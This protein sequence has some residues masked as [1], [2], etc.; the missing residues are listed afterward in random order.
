MLA[1]GST[2]LSPRHRVRSEASNQ[3]KACHYQLPSMSTQRLD[4]SCNFPRRDAPRSQLIRPVGLSVE[5]P[6]EGRGSCSMRPKIRLSPSLASAQTALWEGRREIEEGLWERERNNLKRI[7]EQDSSDEA[8]TN[9]ATKR[10]RSGSGTTTPADS[11]DGERMRMSVN[12]LESGS[13]WFPQTAEVPGPM[14]GFTVDEPPS[15]EPF[16]EERFCFPPMLVSSHPWVESVVTDITDRGE[17]DDE[18]SQDT[19]KA[20]SGS[21]TS[22]ESGGWTQRLEGTSE[23]DDT[24]NHQSQIPYSS[25]GTKL[26][27]GNEGVQQE[28]QGFELVSLLLA[29]VD[30]VRSKNIAAISHCLS[31]L[32]ELACPDGTPIHR[33]TAYFTEGL[34]LRAARLWP[35]TFHISIP[36]EIGRTE[37]DSGTSLRLL[38]HVSPIPKFLHFTSNEMMLRAFEGKDRVHIIDFDIKQGL[39]WPGLFQTLASRSSPPTHVRITGIGES[40]QE[41]QETGD[42]LAGFAGA[43]N[44]PFEF[45]AVVDRLEDVRL[46]MLHVKEKESVA[47]NCIL[48]LHKM[49]YDG[50]GAVLRDFLGLIRSTN[51]TVVLMAE[52]E[53]KHNDPRLELRVSNSLEYYCALFD[54]IDTSLPLNSSVRMKIE[55]MF[56]REIRNIV[57]FEGSDR[58]ERH[59]NFKEWRKLIEHCGFRCMGVGDREMLQSR[60]LLKMYSGEKYRLE[61]QE[62]DGAGLTL[63]WQDQP[64]YTVSAWSPIDVAGSSS[65]V[66][67]PS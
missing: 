3:L 47:V 41:L 32:G 2:L 5:V 28:H 12:Q 42:R 67:L 51:P 10:R 17:N 64:L 46:W 4:F 34:A 15:V 56:A 50:S 11:S 37:E 65:S 21:S 26:L 52:Q 49:L 57:A 55:E 39:Q 19:K 27:T 35:H 16:K 33:V 53:A 61:K 13:F 44:L 6:N 29:C 20:V 22:S 23:D 58:F 8:C 60:M 38:N 66:T 59:E 54:S 14:P 31:R 36:R 40:K 18:S 63:F 7:A 25:E 45:H 62:A 1:G 24:G 30:S 9:R 48:Q 43:L